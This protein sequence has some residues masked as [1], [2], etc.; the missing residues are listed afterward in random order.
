MAAVPGL[1]ASDMV[2][3]DTEERSKI[4]LEELTKYT[5]KAIPLEEIIRRI[6]EGR[7]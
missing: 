5:A 4:H 7:L 3:S 1:C 2:A 6:E